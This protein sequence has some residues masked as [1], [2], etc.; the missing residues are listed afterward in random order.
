[1]LSKP[2]LGLAGT[3]QLCSK[4]GVGVLEEHLVEFD[5][6]VELLRRLRVGE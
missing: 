3:E 1:M 5:F 2:E 6:F 4:K